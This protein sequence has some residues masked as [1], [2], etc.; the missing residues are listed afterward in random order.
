[1][2]APSLASDPIPSRRM[3]RWHRLTHLAALLAPMLFTAGCGGRN[4]A[5]NAALNPFPSPAALDRIRKQPPP[6]PPAPQAPAEVASWTL[7]GPFPTEDP[8]APPPPNAPG[9]ALVIDGSGQAVPTAAMTCVARDLG[10]FV[11]THAALPVD[12]LRTFTASR[13]GAPVAALQMRW[14]TGDAGPDEDAAAILGRWAPDPGKMVAE[15]TAALPPGAVFGAALVRVE[16]RAVW[17]LA[18]QASTTQVEGYTGLPDA[19]GR[20]ALRGRVQ[21]EFATIEALVT[22]GRFGFAPCAPLADTAPGAFA[23][24]CPVDPAD[25]NARIDVLGV[26]PGAILGDRLVSLTAWPGG[27][28]GDTWHA[29]ADVG[30]QVVDDAAQIPPRVAETINRLRATA[31]LA[32]L[33]LDEP[34][35]A[36]LRGLAPYFWAST[37]GQLARGVADQVALGVLAGW[38]VSGLVRGGHFAAA[39]C[40]GR[41]DAGELVREMLASPFDRRALFDP[42]ARR[43]AVGPSALEPA[44]ARLL[45]GTYRLFEADFDAAGAA[46]RLRARLN[47]ERVAAGLGPL[48]EWPAMDAMLGELTAQV[49]AG[50]LTPDEA[51]ERAVNKGARTF[52]GPVTGVVMQGGDIEGF[53]QPEHVRALAGGPVGMAVGHT[54]PPGHPWARYVVL[55]VWPGRMVTADAAGEGAPSVRPGGASGPTFGAAR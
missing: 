34:Q 43:L 28:P 54:K 11:A 2:P 30:D 45:L 20:V 31:K 19:E 22:R 44:R 53:E 48:M 7:E 18:G 17:M 37:G 55:I 9:A 14:M 29:P 12:D 1:M 15:F 51:I 6:P 32:P 5:Q 40:H 13:C 25:A 23:F 38:Q 42:D 46:A 49:S 4:S 41:A 16:G 10:R 35:S 52:R 50:E 3:P 24:D 26:P 27:A 36:E 33:T 21:R 39:E 8:D 47:T